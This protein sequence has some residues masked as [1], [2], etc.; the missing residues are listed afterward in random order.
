MKNESEY[1]INF[2]GNKI[3]SQWNEPS[4]ESIWVSKVKGHDVDVQEGLGKA[5]YDGS[6]GQDVYKRHVLSRP[7]E[8]PSTTFLIPV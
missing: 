3:L 2:V 8:S 1:A 6:T 4:Y 7:P 5:V